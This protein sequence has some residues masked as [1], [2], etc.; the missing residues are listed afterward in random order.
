MEKLDTSDR[1]E[2]RKFGLLMAAAFSVLGGIGW[3]VKGTPASWTF[4]VAAVFLIAAVAAPFALR[5][6][7]AAWMKFAE[8]LNWVMTRVLLTIVFYGMITP[9]R[10]LNQIFGSDPLKRAWMQDADTYWEDPEEQPTD[11]ERYRNQF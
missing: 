11:R 2:Q 10:F 8:A 1:K 4:T 6:V 5:P 9:A 7:F 3:W